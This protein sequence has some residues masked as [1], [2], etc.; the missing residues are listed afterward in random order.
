MNTDLFDKAVKFAVDAHAGIE[1]R[2]KG[3]PYILHPM[4]AAGIVG[5]YNGL[6]AREVLVHSDVE[7]EEILRSL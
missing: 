1:R 4:E 5:P 6:K 2:G 3:Y 7:L